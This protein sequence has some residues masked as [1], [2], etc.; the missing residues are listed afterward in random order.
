MGSGSGPRVLSFESRRQ[1]EMADL[2]RRHG[3]LAT[4]VASVQE[5]PLSDNHKALS[6]VDSLRKGVVDTVVFLTGV[7]AKT[8]AESVSGECP[9]NELVQLLDECTIVVRGPKPAAVL[10]TWGVRIDGRAAEP[11]TW[12]ELLPELERLE[13][14]VE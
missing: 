5:T 8:L 4:V 12:E 6:F 9:L 10:N 7:G 2:I 11:N 1:R 14:V 3:G 13:A